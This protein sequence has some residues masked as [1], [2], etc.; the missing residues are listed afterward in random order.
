MHDKIRVLAILDRLIP[1]SIIG[2][3][4]PLLALQK[5]GEIQFRLAYTGFYKEKDISNSDIVV[6]CRNTRPDD[7]K[8]L[9]YIKK[10][11]K[12]FIYDIDDNFFDLSLDTQLGMYHRHPGHLYVLRTML[13]YA[14]CIRVYSEPMREIAEKINP[15]HVMKV[16]SYFDLSMLE[17][18]APKRHDKIKIVYATS[19]GNADPLAQICVSA[20]KKVLEKYSDTVEYYAFGFIPEALKGYPNVFKLNYIHN[21]AEYI[22]FFYEQGFDIGLAPGI[23]DR[24]HN[25]KTNNK[26]REYGA[27]QVCGIYSD[28]QIYRECIED[29]EEGILVQNTTEDWVSA[30]TEL[31]ENESLRKKIR[32]NAL[33]KV[34]NDYSLENTLNDWRSALYNDCIHKEKAVLIATQKVAVLTLQKSKFQTFRVYP[35]YTVLGFFQISFHVFDLATANLSELNNYDIRICFLPNNM[36]ERYVNELESYGITDG[37]IIDTFRPYEETARFPQV[38]FTNT[39]DKGTN[40]HSIRDWFHMDQEQ[41]DRV[42]EDKMFEQTAEQFENLRLNFQD[43]LRK[44][45]EYQHS[46]DSPAVQWALVL[47]KYASDNPPVNTTLI[48]QLFSKTAGL[49]RKV[50]SKLKKI[51]SKVLSPGVTMAVRLRNRFVYLYRAIE[52]YIRVN[53]FRDY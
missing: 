7:L 17:N 27:M 29:H 41:L 1:S 16:K 37:L 18:N 32:H 51:G 50:F 48:V 13:N 20:I 24:F 3:V 4:R 6:L 49:L 43:V 34:R 40:C 19:R 36:V 39:L 9:Y 28:V 42:A 14:D 10:Y 45:C 25:S 35:L 30:I 26:F 31:L 53:I 33:E 38:V 8:I 15:N 5:S 2:V 44:E 23:D 46:L 12:K 21:Y 22:K 47:E 52:D 11:E